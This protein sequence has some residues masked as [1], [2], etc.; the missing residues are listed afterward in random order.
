MKKYLYYLLLSPFILSIVGCGNGANTHQEGDPSQPPV[1]QKG[2]VDVV[3]ISGQSNGVGCTHSYC[4]PDTVGIEKYQEYF[5][6]YPEIQI[7]FDCWTKDWPAT[8]ITFYRQ[9][10]SSKN[11]FVPTKLGQGNSRGD[12]F[13]PEIGIAEEL[14]ERYANKLFLIKFACGGSN[15]KD[16]WLGSKS[17]MYNRFIDY[18][19][20]QMNNL[21]EMGYTPTIK[22]LCWMQGEGDSY[23]YYYNVYQDNLRQ[24]V[25]DVRNDLKELS[26]NKDLAF[27]DA[28]INNNTDLWQYYKEVNDAK[29]AFSNESENNIF[30]DTIAAKLHTNLEPKDNVDYAHYDSDSQVLLGHLFAQAFEQ[31]LETPEEK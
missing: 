6:G 8:G 27:I 31:F 14:H 29:I 16:D 3:L 20:L 22:A 5:A 21:V 28:A 15:L 10:S 2:P 9:N 25:S 12:T 7:A 23:P 4:L 18:V 30:I 1:E 17:A 26:G 19:K 24:F 13:G 11:S